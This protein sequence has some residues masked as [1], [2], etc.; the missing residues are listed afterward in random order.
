MK[1]VEGYS[2]ASYVR[3]VVERLPNMYKALGSVSSPGKN[4]GVQV[5]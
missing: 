1:S 3:L 4:I 2:E 5:W